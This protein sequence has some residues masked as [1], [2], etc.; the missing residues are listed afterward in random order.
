MYYRRYSIFFRSTLSKSSIFRNLYVAQSTRN[1]TSNRL[2]AAG[3][4]RRCL[5]LLAIGM[6]AVLMQCQQDDQRPPADPDHG[7]L[8]LP[9]GFEAMVVV[10]SLPGRARHLAVRDNGDI[11]VKNRYT[12]GGGSVTALR[13]TDHD[14][15]AD[16][17]KSF[18]KSPQEH[19][20]GTSVR[21]HDRYL[22]FSTELMVYRYALTSELV[23]TGEMEVIL[24]D[25]HEHGM[26]EHITKPLAFDD[27]GYM[28]V[29]FGAPSNACQ[30][31]KRTPGVPGMD[32]CPQLED[33]GG[34][35]RFDA[36]KT[37]LTQQDGERFATG[38]R[39]IVAMEW[40]RTDNQL[41][42][43]MHGR[44]D[45][46]RLWADR[47]SPW[48][49]ALLPSEEFLKVT[50]GA[51]FGWPYCYYDQMKGQKVLAPEYGGDGSTVGRCTDCDDPEMGFPGHWAPNDLF[52]YTGDQFPKRYQ[53]GAFVAFHGSTNRAPYPQS[54]YFIGFIPFVDG[55]PTGEFEVFADGFAG[56]DP[57]VNVSDAMYR[58]M[59]IAM[60][61][62]G[63]LYL[64]DTEKGKIWRVMYRGDRESFGE[65]QLAAMEEHKELAHIRTPDQVE[66]NLDR[67][68]VVEG[69]K[70]FST[71]CAACHQ[72][73]GQGD[74][75]RFPTLVGSEWVL[76]E[77]SRLISVILNGLEGPIKVKGQPYNNLMPQHSFLSDEE[78]AQVLTYVR[79][80]LGN[81][82]TEV[83]PE[84]V[85][86]VRA[87]SSGP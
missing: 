60:G 81:Q 83:T 28:Y 10:D 85:E 47:Y 55:A 38:L 37:G 27:Q 35:W 6:S 1:M 40:N 67:G 51:D 7:G 33:H 73:N 86:A 52:F 49:S 29:P 36:T 4:F 69:G 64:G 32:P 63:S 71:Y 58:P 30:D 59:G 14:G 41:Y 18:G 56:V 62:D 76:G 42:V 23:P 57:I 79:Q 44:D 74:S 77:K 66:D 82:A 25:D 9:D 78:V 68:L 22:Y 80:N 50:Q 45:L 75:Q 24:T 87:S 11:F 19:G 12:T 48:Q 65:T 20:Y 53:Q 46:L 3:R 13:D 70:V 61:P 39:S 34:I 31:P 15:R 2:V 8:A 26:H 84:E 5:Y 21:I 17:I 43:V 54:G 16:I 72:T